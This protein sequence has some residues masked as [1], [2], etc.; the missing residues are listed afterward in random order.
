MKKL[1]LIIAVLASSAVVYAD[2]NA[3]EA[4]IDSRYHSGLIGKDEAVMETALLQN[5]KPLDIYGKVVNQAGQPISGATIAGRIRVYTGYMHSGY[6]DLSV[7]TDAD[8]RF[9]FPG[10]HGVKL[11]I[12]PSKDGYF[13]NL[14]QSTKRPDD[15]RPDPA[16]PVIFQM[17]KAH[18]TE[19]LAGKSIQSSVPYNGFARAKPPLP[20]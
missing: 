15:Y 14:K 1:L 8:G 16:N 3:D 5:K 4:D 10:I 13:Y 20:G 18:G 17:W 9:S 6:Q 2:T 7:I 11:G 19:P 12:V